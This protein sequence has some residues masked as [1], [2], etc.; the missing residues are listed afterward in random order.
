MKKNEDGRKI[1]ERYTDANMDDRSTN[2][3]T[4]ELVF[5]SMED[6]STV[7]ETVELVIV[8]MEDGRTSVETV[9][10]EPVTALTIGKYLNVV[11]VV[12]NISVFMTGERKGVQ[13]VEVVPYVLIRNE[14]I[15]A[16]TVFPLNK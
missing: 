5:V 13:R 7:V 10:L 2:V 4:A 1:W 9:E 14:K 11:F 8:S 16:L 3:E 15:S 6:L 12:L